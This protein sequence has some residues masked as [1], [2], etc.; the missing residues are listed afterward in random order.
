MGDTAYHARL[1]AYHQEVIKGPAPLPLDRLAE[2]PSAADDRYRY[3]PLLLV[4]LEREVGAQRMGRLLHAIPTAPAGEA[5]EYALLHRA[6]LEAGVPGAVWRRWEERCVR[7]AP[8]ASCLTELT[9]AT[10]LRD[11][12]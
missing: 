3:G 8:I 7:P 12:A 4:A 9:P 5:R 10:P 1:K 6:A 2:R 11:P